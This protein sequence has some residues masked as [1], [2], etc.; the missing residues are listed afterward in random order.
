MTFEQFAYIAVACAAL[1]IMAYIDMKRTSKHE[2]DR[3]HRLHP[4]E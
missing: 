2:D 4:G 3:K 1:L